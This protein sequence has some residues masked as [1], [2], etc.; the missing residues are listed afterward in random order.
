M[1]WTVRT[2]QSELVSTPMQTHSLPARP[3]S[4]K[5]ASTASGPNQDQMSRADGRRFVFPITSTDRVS[6]VRHLQVFSAIEGLLSKMTPKQILGDSCFGQSEAVAKQ[7]RISVPIAD[8]EADGAASIAPNTAERRTRAM[9]SSCVVP[10]KI[11]ALTRIAPWKIAGARVY[12]SVSDS[13]VG[14]RPEDIPKA[15]EPYGQVDASCKRR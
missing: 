6:C 8:P 3:N 2:T 14:M 7:R 5:K 4:V 10:A 9:P 15:L 11:A 13:G 12:T 1:G